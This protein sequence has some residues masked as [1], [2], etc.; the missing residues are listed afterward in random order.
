MSRWD[1]DY[2]VDQALRWHASSINLKSA[3]VPDDYWPHVELMQKRM[4]YRIAP[5]TVRWAD[6]AKPGGALTLN[7]IW[8]NQGIAPPYHG[9]ACQA[10]LKSKH[11][12]HVMTIAESTADWMPGYKV[13]EQE[14]DVPGD[15]KP[16]KYALQLALTSPHSGEACV[17]LACDLE[18]DGL[19]YEVGGVE[20]VSA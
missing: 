6:Q 9:Y 19:W 10:R 15:V 5:R 11:E 14:L 7:S 18:A 4:G 17:K 3:P 12:S 13:F 2:I 1:I 20:I 8:E 16:G